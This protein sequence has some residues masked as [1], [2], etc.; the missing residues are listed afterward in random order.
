M[1]AQYILLCIHSFVE[2][3][4]FPRVSALYEVYNLYRT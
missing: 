3:E 2:L 4:D 1:Y